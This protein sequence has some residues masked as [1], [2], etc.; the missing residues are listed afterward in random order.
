MKFGRNLFE[1]NAHQKAIFGS[2]KKMTIL[3]VDHQVDKRICFIVFMF[4]ENV[5]EYEDMPYE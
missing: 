1:Q 5:D 3:L 2:F 4:G